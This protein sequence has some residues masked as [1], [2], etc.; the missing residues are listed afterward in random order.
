M[1]KNPNSSGDFSRRDFLRTS[2]VAVG[3]AL[4]GNI[5]AERGA[6]AAGDDTVKVALIGCGGRG[7]GAAG[8][9]LSTEGSVRLVAMADIFEDHLTSKLAVLQKNAKEKVDVPKD[10]QFIGF[11]AYKEAIA[12]ADV[13]ILTTPPGIR[14]IHFEEAVRQGK[15]IFMEKPVAVDGPGIRRVL[16]AAEEAKKKSL[17]IGVGLQR[18]HQLP[19]IETIKRLHDG[20]IGDITSMRCYWNG[21]TPWVHTREDL[22]RQAGR[23]LTDMEYQFRNWYYFVWLCGDHIV[24][25]HIHNLDVINWV[26]NGFPVKARGMGGCEVRKGKDYGEIFD[27]HAVEFEYADGSICFSECRHQ[28]GCWNSVSEHVVGT[29]GS[30]HVGGD[31]GGHTIRGENAWRFPRGTPSRDP[32]QQ[33]HDDLFAAIRKNEAFNEVE[34]GAKST[35]T[36]IL[37]RMATYS[38]KEISFEQALNS[39]VDHL[40]KIFAWDAPAPVQPNSEGYYSTPVPGDSEWLKKI[41]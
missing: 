15:N 12:L 18:H 34:R 16:A 3:G 38:G 26:K 28:P 27:H 39:Q 25:Q 31:T 40:P 23:P 22:E 36:A 6:H 17:K 4:L 13:V 1:Q 10:R 35:L 2:S 30:C 5:S 32:Y 37:G 9:A 11:D 29:K 33:E 14:P 7:T 8:Q 19:Y 41:V 24:E 21:Q 20:A